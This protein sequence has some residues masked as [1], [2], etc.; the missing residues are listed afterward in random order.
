MLLA[1]LARVEALLQ[2]AMKMMREAGATWQEIIASS[3][4]T[5]I[6]GVKKAIDPQRR[7]RSNE[8][9][10]TKRRVAAVNH[11]VLT[12]DATEASVA[13]GGYSVADAKQRGSWPA[14]ADRGRP[15]R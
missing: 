13:A 2:P 11:V 10:R 15:E 9:A 12:D 14:C 8:N 7:E 4:Y 6:E 5:S 3:G 1:E